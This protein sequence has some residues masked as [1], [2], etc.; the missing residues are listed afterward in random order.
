MPQLLGLGEPP[1][2]RSFIQSNHGHTLMAYLLK[3]NY[4]SY[5][6][7]TQLTEEECVVT[8]IHYK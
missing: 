3:T 2:T 8:I 6:T 4:L 5:G 1:Y 7:G